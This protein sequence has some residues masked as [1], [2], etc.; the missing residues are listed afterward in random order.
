MTRGKSKSEQKR[1]VLTLGER[2]DLEGLRQEE[3]A[4][5]KHLESN[6]GMQRA[7]TIDKAAIQRNIAKYD[8][9]LDE[10]SPNVVKGK[11]KDGLKIEADILVEAFKVNMPSWDEMNNPA[12]YPGAIHKHLKWTERNDGKVRRFKDIMR[13]L[14]PD[15]PTAMDIDRFRNEK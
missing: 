2:T 3:K 7:G 4:T 9:I 10:G 15:D 13:Q 5:L 12:K 11:A 8:K 6:T 14:E 1:R